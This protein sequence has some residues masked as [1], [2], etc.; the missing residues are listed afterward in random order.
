MKKRR[1]K[2]EGVC[3]S[4][5][6]SFTGGK[7]SNHLEKCRTS[8]L[9]T[10]KKSIEMMHIL[11]QGKFEPDYWLQIAVP[12][13]ATLFD[14]DEFLRYTWLECCGH[15]SQFR[16]NGR[17]Y[18]LDMEMA[19]DFHPFDDVS[20]MSTQLSNALTMGD[21]FDYEYDFGSSTDLKLEVLD[22]FKASPDSSDIYLLAHNEKPEDF[23]SK[24]AAPATWIEAGYMDSSFFCDKCVDRESDEI[25]VLPLVNSPRTGVC[26]YEGPVPFESESK[27]STPPTSHKAKSSK[28]RKKKKEEKID[29]IQQLKSRPDLCSSTFLLDDVILEMWGDCSERIQ[30]D[31]EMELEE[32]LEEDPAFVSTDS[33]LDGSPIYHHLA[34]SFE[35]AEFLVKPTK[36][37]LDDGI[38]FPGHRFIPFV[39]EETLSTQIVLKYGDKSITTKKIL[40]PLEKLWLY[41]SLLGPAGTMEYLLFE[42]TDNADQIYGE[43]DPGADFSLFVMDMKNFYAENDFKLGDAILMSVESCDNAEL[44]MKYLSAED[45]AERKGEIPKWCALFSDGI[46]K[47]IDTHG[48]YLSIREEVAIA[49]INNA[50][51]LLSNPVIH[52]GGFLA[53]SQKYSLTHIEGDGIIWF[54]GEEPPSLDDENIDFDDVMQSVEDDM[55]SL[56]DKD[57]MESIFKF[58][59]FDFVDAEIEEYMRDE[60]FNGGTSPESAWERCLDD[61]INIV[62]EYLEYQKPLKS[63]FNKM[64]KK[65]SKSYNRFTDETKGKI[66]KRA[67][68]VKDGQTKWM[69]ELI[70]IVQDY[71]DLDDDG[72]RELAQISG[73]ISQILISLNGDDKEISKKEAKQFEKTFDMLSQTIKALQK[74]VENNIKG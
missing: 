58:M 41:H 55:S 35:G 1:F 39:T 29:F 25:M 61:R 8:L 72:F 65:V 31:A 64:W 30:I 49:L 22:V 71:Q 63:L 59:G 54:H 69:R 26:A 50:D 19:E 24:C 9:N 42:D 51:Y 15:L 66:R 2:T 44:S 67:L 16:I 74:N 32:F 10:G 21:Q 52:I 27:K 38:L 13:S 12:T 33:D 68:E 48:P 40:K 3:K 4:C 28:K 5:G 56:P 17:Y 70:D 43:P 20:S 45:L 7:I 62:P 11:I 73:M 18:E 37:E 47:A 36:E 14:I 53:L 57:S 23:C 34:T 6:Q 46:E 60:L